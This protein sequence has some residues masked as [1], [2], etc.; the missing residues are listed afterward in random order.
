MT[1]A[2][3]VPAPGAIRSLIPARIDRPALVP[4]P[5]PHGHRARRGVG[6]RRPRD[7]R[8]QRRRR[9]PSPS[10]ETLALYA[11][12]RS[13]CIATV[14]LAGR[15]GRRAGLRPAVRTSS[16]G[17]TSFMVTLAVYLIGSGLTALT[18]GQRLGLWLIFL[19]PHPVHRR[20]G[21]RRR[22]RRDQLRDRRADPGP[23]PRPGRHRG[24]RHLLGRRDHRHARHLHPAQPG[25]PGAGLAARLPARP[26]ARR[27]DP[28]SC[29]GTCRR[30]RAGWSCTAGRPRPR[31]PS[32][33]SSTR[34]AQART[35][36][37]P[38]VDESKAI[39]LRPADDI[40]YRG[41]DRGCCS[42]S[43]RGD[44]SSARR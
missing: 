5:H 11:A 28:A 34:S 6:P 44:R 17:G 30:A 12:R 35:G 3:Q 8:R 10:T 13:G 20:H 43:T 1:T 37:C 16:A 31:R 32:T 23:V 9:R 2:S 29:G 40:G 4:V 15:G 18:L 14:Y 25:R 39:E 38:P 41:A 27:G 19:V 33:G 42:A 24:Q 7:H 26:G 36:R 21:H 22:V